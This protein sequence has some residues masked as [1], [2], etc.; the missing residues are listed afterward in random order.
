LI[1]P[2]TIFENDD[3]KRSTIQSR[4]IRFKAIL[5]ASNRFDR[6]VGAGE[7]ASGSVVWRSIVRRSV[8]KSS[9]SAVRQILVG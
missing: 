5:D 1:E 2:K 4:P 9:G 3:E 6:D 7:L 8:S